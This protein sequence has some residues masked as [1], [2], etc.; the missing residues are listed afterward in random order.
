[1][2]LAREVP[3][4]VTLVSENGL[5]TS[6]DLRMLRAHGYDGFLI[7]EFLMRAEEPARPWNL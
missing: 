4:E 2:Q 3:E 6:D 1:M 5:S 7:G